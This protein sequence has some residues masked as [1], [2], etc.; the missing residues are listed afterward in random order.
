MAG[1]LLMEWGERN[2]GYKWVE[3]RREARVDEKVGIW[4]KAR[5]HVNWL[6][7]LQRLRRPAVAAVWA[8][9]RRPAVH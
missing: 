4:V 7:L 5:V 1:D 9:A 2:M 8:E 6:S 3:M